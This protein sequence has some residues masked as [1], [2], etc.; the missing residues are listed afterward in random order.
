[1]TTL[2]EAPHPGSF[3]ISEEDHFHTRDAALIALSQTLKAGQVLG[4]RGVIAGI[5]SS[6]A[7][8]ASNTG[9]GTFT[10]DA[11]APVAASAR[12]GVYRAICVAV[13]TNSGTFAVFDPN[14]IE[15]GRVAVGA[16]FNNQ[17]KFVIADGAT[18]FA[19]G[20]AFSVTVGIELSDFE[21]A[22]FDH[23]A[24]DGLQLVAGVAIYPITTDGTT[25]KPVAV[26]VRGPAQV[27]GSD[28]IWSAGISA[29]Q[30]AE[31]IRQLERL[32]IVT[33]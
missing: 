33:R 30:Q 22:A 6:A 9:N 31:G 19:A 1:M 21:Y 15:I 5:T 32:G 29:A 18:D 26:L 27:R 24:T 8:D 10:L 7:A 3:L 13:A 17:I 4:R 12:N 20:D 2:T 14:G 28:L 25:K 11:T 23:T 16:T